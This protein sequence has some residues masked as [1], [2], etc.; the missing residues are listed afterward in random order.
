[1]LSALRSFVYLPSSN[2]K[3]PRE[4]AMTRSCNRALEHRSSRKRT[5]LY[6]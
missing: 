4:E 5:T 1:M 2:V 3:P 6:L